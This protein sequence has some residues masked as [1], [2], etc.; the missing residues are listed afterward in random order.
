MI[1]AQLEEWAAGLNEVKKSNLQEALARFSKLA[2]SL[3]KLA[4]NCGAIHLQLG[5]FADAVRVSHS[6]YFLVLV[7]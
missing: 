6:L 2:S 1:F 7:I 3:A 5:Q 4:Y